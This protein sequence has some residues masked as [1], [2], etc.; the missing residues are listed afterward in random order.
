MSIESGIATESRS[1]TLAM[2]SVGLPPSSIRSASDMK[3]NFE[4]SSQLWS[5]DRSADSADRRPWGRAVPE[6]SIWGNSG[7]SETGNSI[8][9]TGGGSLSTMWQHIAGEG[10]AGTKMAEAGSADLAWRNAPVMS[11]PN[12]GSESLGFSDL[13]QFGGFGFGSNAAESNSFRPFSGSGDGWGMSS[14]TTA[15][16]KLASADWDITKDNTVKSDQS[17]GWPSDTRENEKTDVQQSTWPDSDLNGAA[18]HARSS[19]AVFDSSAGKE[20]DSGKL[21]STSSSGSMDPASSS[22]P[23]PSE[24]TAEELLIAKMINSHEGW[25]TR[26]VRQDTPW[27]IETSSPSAGAV[28]GNVM[29]NVG[30]AVKG[31]VG[32]VWNSPKDITGAGQYWGGG[33]AGAS[34]TEWSSDHDIGVWN[35]S[36]SAAAVNPNMWTSHAGAAAG[37]PNSAARIN[38]SDFA[39]ALAAAGRWPDSVG[40]FP[41]TVMNKLTSAAA[42][43]SLD[44]N[45]P[46]DAQWIAALTK[47]QPSGGWASDPN[48]ASWGTA[49]AHDPAGALI[50]AQLQLGA[51]PP[52]LGPVGNQFEVRPSTTGLKIDT[53]NEPPTVPDTLL[54]PGHWGQTPVNAVCHLGFISRLQCYACVC[55]CNFIYCHIYFIVNTVIIMN[56]LV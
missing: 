26:P 7:A 20:T 40:S 5:T 25:G 30:G 3:S 23:Q 1:E 45:R 8:W 49:D 31:D 11:E 9:N 21:P 27:V 36:P 32:S 48:P 6:F 22:T 10:F 53:W 28:V 54:H 2:D 43:S 33:P 39:T 24:L 37:W 56:S 38:S 17:S 16:S 18:A 13:R 41:A 55:V 15:E 29:E 46:T 4:A 42:N 51:Q 34:S 50:R 14:S 47:A 44:K 19:S 12:G 35:E 52:R